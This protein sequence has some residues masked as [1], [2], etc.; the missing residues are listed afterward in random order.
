LLPCRSQVNV[1][2]AQGWSSD[3][4]TLE[5]G[6]TLR[7]RLPAE[8]GREKGSPIAPVTKVNGRRRGAVSELALHCGI[9]AAESGHRGMCQSH[10]SHPRG[11]VPRLKFE[12]ALHPQLHPVV[13]V[14]ELSEIVGIGGSGIPWRLGTVRN[15][16]RS[17]DSRRLC[18][19][20]SHAVVIDELEHGAEERNSRGV[21]CAI[22]PRD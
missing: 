8:R 3:R 15:S 16:A 10:R 19:T 9:Y 1:S 20:L 6:K 14:E 12:N 11:C 5:R 4:G 22:Q 18:R 7:Q 2:V 21:A 17:D 13:Q